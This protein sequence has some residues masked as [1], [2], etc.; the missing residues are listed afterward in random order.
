MMFYDD[1]KLKKHFSFHGVYFFATIYRNSSYFVSGFVADY[2]YLSCIVS[3][4]CIVVFIF[5]KH[6]HHFLLYHI[7]H[8]M[9]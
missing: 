3:L 7:M 5:L 6:L 4:P 8:C 2:I 9:L 1:F